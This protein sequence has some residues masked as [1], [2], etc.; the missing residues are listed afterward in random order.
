MPERVPDTGDLE[1][2]ADGRQSRQDDHGQ[3]HRQRP[4]AGPVRVVGRRLLGPVV[5]VT[6]PTRVLEHEVGRL[7]V[8]DEEEQPERVDAGQE[9]AQQPCDQQDP[10]VGAPARQ[11]GGKDRVLR[12]ETGERRDA[13]QGQRADHEHQ[14]RP[15][16]EPAET[17]HPADVLLAGEVVDDQPRGEEEQRLEERVREQVEHPVGVRA[18]P[19]AEEHVADLRHRRVGDHLLDVRLH[20]RDQPRDDECGGAQPGGEILD[21]RRSLEDRVGANDQ[22]D[23]GG[24]HRR[25]VDQR[26]HRGRALHGVREPRLER[27]LRRLGDG[28]TEE[29]ERDQVHGG[30]VE[31]GGAAEGD[32]EVERPGLED[33]QEEPERHRGVADRVHHERLLG[34][35]DRLRPVVPESDQEV[36]GE[37]DEPPAGEEEQ[38]VAGL[39]EHQH[40]EDEDRHVGEVAAL[41][42]VPVHVADR[43]ED[44]QAADAGDDEHHHDRHGVDQ[45]RH[46]HMEGAT[47]QP[48]V[49]GRE[50]AA[51]GG[52]PAPH[53]EERDERTGE[54]DEDRERPQIGGCAAR[55]RRPG[56]RDGE[57][58]RE[59]CEQADPAA[60]GESV[61]EATLIRATP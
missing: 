36:R 45:D 56:E 32:S 2:A 10:A 1:Q 43:V 44:D 25:R 8:E 6:V 58:T 12:P 42:V 23:T 60:G 29:P 22:V 33:E 3:H 20:Q 41:L 39:D 50:L 59:R 17:A 7:A 51:V 54:P 61:H 19:G 9:R 16:H 31:V 52:A 35:R 27:Q 28:A 49:G 18:E 5:V 46:P 57:R 26:R 48:R 37:T 34:G 38:Q 30:R 14:P 24:D 40:R 11:R 21:V 15:R 47:S 55:D 53:A 13:D 4:L